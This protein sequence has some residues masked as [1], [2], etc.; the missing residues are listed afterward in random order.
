M[1]FQFPSKIILVH[2]KEIIIGIAVGTDARK[3][4][5][6]VMQSKAI[7]EWGAHCS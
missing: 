2:I 5:E 1:G 6:Y 3:N 4:Y 7:E